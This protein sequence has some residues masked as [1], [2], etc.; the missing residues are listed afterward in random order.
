MRSAILSGTFVAVTLALAGQ[1]AAQ[2][3]MSGAGGNTATGEGSAS[4]STHAGPGNSQTG[5]GQAAQPAPAPRVVSRTAR[6]VATAAPAPRHAPHPVATPRAASRTAPIVHP[7]TQRV[8][9]PARHAARRPTARR[10]TA[11]RSAA[12]PQRN[13]TLKR[14]GASGVH[15]PARGADANVAATPSAEPA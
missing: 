3:G 6:P 7:P 5:A 1:A 15:A 12:T 11:R 9:A 13:A 8:V 2:D 14:Q 4:G 10:P